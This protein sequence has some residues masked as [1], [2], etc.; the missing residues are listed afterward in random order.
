MTP[1]ESPS[2]TTDLS[3]GAEV[4][5]SLETILASQAFTHAPR[6]Q[7]FLRFVIEE[8]LAGRAGDLKEPVVA[9]RVFNLNARFDRRNNSIVRAEATHVRRRLRDY[10]LGAGGADPVVIDLPRGGYAPVIRTVAS[11]GSKPENA[12]HGQLAA[13]MSWLRPGK[14]AARE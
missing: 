8:T 9:A 10:Y 4:R 1:D 2:S 5:R 7:Q 11:G 13:F 3:D 12:S 14:G 6:A